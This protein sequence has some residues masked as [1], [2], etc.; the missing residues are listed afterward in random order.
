MTEWVKP[1]NQDA[2]V[3]QFLVALE[4]VIKNRRKLGKLNTIT[5]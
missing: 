2:R 4:L 1:A 5:A 3:A